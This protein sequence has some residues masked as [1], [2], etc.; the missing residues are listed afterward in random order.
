MKKLLVLALLAGGLLSACVVVPRHGAV[1]PYLP[2]LVVLDVEPYYYYEGY[3]YHYYG[4]RWYWSNSRRGPWYDLPHDHYPKELRYKGRGRGHG[5]D[6][7]YH[8]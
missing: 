3:H 1:V 4:D 2:P 7:H 8:D 6:R 5:H